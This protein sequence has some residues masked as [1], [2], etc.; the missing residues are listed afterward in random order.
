M[1][2][3]QIVC[4]TVNTIV[5]F[6]MDTRNRFLSKRITEECKERLVRDKGA[7]EN[8]ECYLPRVQRDP[9]A[10]SQS[11]P[12]AYRPRFWKVI[13][14]KIMK[15]RKRCYIP[16]LDVIRFVWDHTKAPYSWEMAYYRS[17]WGHN[18][19]L[20]WHKFTIFHELAKLYVQL[21][22]I[23]PFADGNTFYSFNTIY[24]CT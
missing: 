7:K 10:P 21:N 19:S 12:G 4:N 2:I 13:K 23:S 20:S 22:G 5:T 8:S 3:Y 17:T 15:R 11:F 14:D 16:P 24:N 1:R 6:G 9:F 18:A